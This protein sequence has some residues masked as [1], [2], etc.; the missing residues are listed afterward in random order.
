MTTPTLGEVRIFAGTFAP[1]GWHF[2]DGSL[3]PIANNEALFA[4]LG[5][6]YGGDGITT[7]ALP[8][9]QGRNAAGTGAGPGLPVMDQ[10]ETGGAHAQTMTIQN[11]PSHSHS[12]G[13]SNAP[14]N[15]V[16]PEGQYFAELQDSTGTFSVNGYV[17]GPGDTTMSAHT[18]SPSG[19]GAPFS[20]TQPYL[21]LNFI[22]A[23]EG[24][25]PSRN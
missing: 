25:F 15:S 18:L 19:Y 2:C 11:M 10:G 14:G 5:T 3:I 7:F 22:I 16:H 24:I 4:L 1:Y 17:S 8:N 9:L 13:V 23:M 21:G 6:I 20:T 12:M